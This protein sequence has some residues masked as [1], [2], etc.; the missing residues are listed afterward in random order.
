M[1]VGITLKRFLMLATMLASLI[2]LAA[3]PTTG[4]ARQ[5]DWQA[6][7][8]Q[9]PAS[10]GTPPDIGSPMFTDPTFSVYPPYTCPNGRMKF[11]HVD[12]GYILKVTGTCWESPSLSESPS[13]ALGLL[14]IKDLVLPDGEAR[15]D[16]KV[17]SGQDRASVI[18]GFREQPDA[19]SYQAVVL[20]GLGEAD[21]YRGNTALAIRKDV[22][23]AISRDDWNTLAVRVRGNDLWVLVNDQLVL[24]ANDPTYDRGRLTFSL[25]RL[26]DVNDPPE[27]AAVF[28]NLRIS[29]LANGDPSRVPMF[30]QVPSP[31]AAAAPTANP[32]QPGQP[33]PDEGRQHTPQ[34]APVQYQNVPPSSGT[35]YPN[36]T[37]PGVY[38]ETQ[39]TGNW[40][41]SLEH[42]YIAILYNCAEPC[43]DL[44]AQLSAFYESAPPSAQYKYQKLIIMP[45]AAMPS[46][47]TAVAWNRRLELDQFDTAQLMAFFRAYQDKGP[48]DAG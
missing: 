43:P 23:S 33:V 41:H 2:V 32:D 29:P 16:F 4:A 44:V 19:F 42:G 35:H 7:P 36:W 38:S 24:Q 46:R 25:R 6:A 30:Q 28:R 27:T 8:G 5:L 9:T 39:E 22:G 17:V 37:R 48:E 15:F 13:V 14:R 47:I 3:S 1:L 26:G 10:G 45:Y 12:E 31:P 18:L 20:P 40:V 21:L 11:E 34:G